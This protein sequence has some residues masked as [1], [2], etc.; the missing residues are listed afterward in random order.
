MIS[1]PSTE[2]KNRIH[3][4]CAY[5]SK[6]QGFF[7]SSSRQDPVLRAAYVRFLHNNYEA[8]LCFAPLQGKD[9][10]KLS[11]LMHRPARMMLQ[12]RFTLKV[13]IVKCVAGHIKLYHVVIYLIQ[14][15]YAFAI[16]VCPSKS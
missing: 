1:V 2:G 15:A 13:S 8:T 4:G 5:F 11:N 7:F 16:V 9:P 14:I 12:F 10:L 6:G 3:V